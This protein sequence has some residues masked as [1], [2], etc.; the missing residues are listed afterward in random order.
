MSL[1]DSIRRYEKDL[2]LKTLEENKYNKEKTAEDLQVGLSTLYR[3]L[4]ELDIKT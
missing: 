3:K 4:K 1:D 2:I